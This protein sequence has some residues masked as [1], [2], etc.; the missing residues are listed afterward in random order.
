VTFQTFDD[1]EERKDEG[2]P[3]ILHGPLIQHWRRLEELNGRGAGVFVMVNEGD[4]QGRKNENVKRVRALFIDNDTPGNHLV[5]AAN[6]FAKL[7]PSISVQSSEG[8]THHYWLVDDC[9]LE[10]FRAAQEQLSQ[11]FKTDGAVKGLAWVLRLTGFF[12]QKKAP[13]LVR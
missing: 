3:H 2:L 4:G 7:P 12:H 5:D 9:P 6:T 1:N 10:E 8:K 13:Y 11:H